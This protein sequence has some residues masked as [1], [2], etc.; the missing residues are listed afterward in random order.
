MRRRITPTPTPTPMPTL[1]PVDMLPPDPEDAAAAVEVAEDVTL[2]LNEDG[3][4]DATGSDVVV[5][6]PVSDGMVEPVDDGLAAS[7]V[8]VGS[9]SDLVV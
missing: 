8:D 9:D 5:E 4:S 6:L 2:D 3:I 1:A 7:S